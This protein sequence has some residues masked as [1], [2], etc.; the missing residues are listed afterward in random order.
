M[1]P[2][3]HRRLLC[4]FVAVLLVV[5]AAAVACVESLDQRPPT[6]ERPDAYV[7]SQTYDG[8]RAADP[9][10][11][12]TVHVSG[13]GAP[14]ARAGDTVCFT[15]DLP[16][17]LT[18]REGGTAEAPITYSGGA[19]TTVPGIT[20]E[21]DHVVVEGFIA[22][23][24][25]DT[26]IWVSGNGITVRDNEISAISLTDDDVDAIRFFGDDITIARN[27][28]HDVWA[29]PDPDRHPH[30]DCMQTFAHAEPASS[31]VRIEGNRCE[32]LTSQCV[33]AEGPNDF[34]DGASGVGES[35]DW[36][37]AGNFFECHAEAQT[38]QLQDIH[39]VTFSQNTFAG[40]GNKAIA[41]GADATGATVT[42]D[43]VLGPGYGTLV[44]F[45]HE[46]ARTGYTGPSPGSG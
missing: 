26:G 27:R 45:D 4:G 19:T 7:E 10:P 30:V 17:R 13:T 12:C 22:R 14:A 6:A 9:S 43:N 37:I 29:N 28:A 38:V 8:A 33:M 31:N 11:A 15:G 35:K 41:L 36:V 42:D 46:S 1:R 23:D 16:S 44:D 34:E 24:A 3:L 20:V 2:H 39:N 5:P 18:I 21:A 25:D 32:G 40:T